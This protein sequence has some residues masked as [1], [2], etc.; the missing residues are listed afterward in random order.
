[1]ALHIKFRSHFALE[2][3][4]R[5]GI[6]DDWSQG[7]DYV[8]FDLFFRSVGVLLFFLGVW[9]LVGLAC[10]PH[11]LLGGIATGAPA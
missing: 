11:C 3:Y 9:R 1:M 6:G 5:G 2:Q 8:S 7:K 4:T 10:W